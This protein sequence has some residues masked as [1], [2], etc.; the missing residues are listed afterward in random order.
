M[1]SPAQSRPSPHPSLCLCQAQRAR[2]GRRG[3]ATRLEELSEEQHPR[4]PDGSV[5]R[6]PLPAA[7]CPARALPAPGGSQ[8]L[9]GFGGQEG[10]GRGHPSLGW[11]CW[12]GTGA[13]SSYQHQRESGAMWSRCPGAPLPTAPPG[14]HAGGGGMGHPSKHTVPSV[15]TPQAPAVCHH[16][17]PALP[18]H[19]GS[20]GTGM[21]GAREP[22]EQGAAPPLPES[23]AGCGCERQVRAGEGC[24]EFVSR[25]RE[26]QEQIL[27]INNPAG[28]RLCRRREGGRLHPVA[29]RVWGGSRQ[30]SFVAA[31]SQRGEWHPPCP[32]LHFSPGASLH[33]GM[34]FLLLVGTL[35]G[36]VRK[37]WVPPGHLGPPACSHHQLTELPSFLWGSTHPCKGRQGVCC[38]SD[39]TAGVEDCRQGLTIPQILHICLQEPAPAPGSLLWGG[40]SP[41]GTAQRKGEKG[42][43]EHPW[44]AGGG[45][46]R[47]QNLWQS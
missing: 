35:Q 28:W 44:G 12:Q 9:C 27:I 38:P 24:L 30:Q 31:T 10:W 2:A 41:W 19:S 22:P 36:G 29:K 25:S 26:R 16:T 15:P 42:R 1:A 23:P 37:L 40:C 11:H 18:W 20:P 43:S 17:G 21:G 45:M 34:G 46:L 13:P 32:L 3:A 8:L 5:A 47:L 7:G 6:G 14:Q 33:L 39:P 4:A